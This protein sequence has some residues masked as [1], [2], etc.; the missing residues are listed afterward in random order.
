MVQLITIEM[1]KIFCFAVILLSLQLNLFSQDLEDLLSSEEEERTDYTTATFKATR[2]VNGHSIERMQ[3]GQLD[4]RIDHRFGELS[5]GSYEFFG[6]DR[7]FVHLSLEYGLNDWFMFGIGRSAYQK[8]VDGFTKFS[9]LRQSKGKRTMPVSMTLLLSSDIKG[10][11]PTTAL[12]SIFI[13]RISYSNQILIARKINEKLSLQLMPTYVHKN[14]VP[15]PDDKNDFFALGIG[16]RYKLTSRL[17][18][19]TEYY[20]VLYPS[21]I[22][23]TYEAHNPLS[24]GFDIETGGH[25]FQLFFSNSIWNT[26]RGY[27]TDTNG[28]WLKGDIHFGFKISRVFP[29]IK[30]KVE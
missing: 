21:F 23:M 20:Y 1:K 14:L 19:N 17:S 8:T 28:D 4:F 9:I 12:D 26:E 3:K 22:A 7:G 5:S 29:L 25:V 10:T 15:H 6:L 16:G 27:I 13:N 30:R 11:K 2:L 18:F 24:V